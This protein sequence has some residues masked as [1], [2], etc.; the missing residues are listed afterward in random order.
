VLQRVKSASVTVDEKTVSSIG[1][2]VMALVGLHESDTT[3]DLAYC[4]KKLIA[5]RLWENENAKP[6]R[7]SV[8]Q[9]DYEVLLVSQFTL[10]GDVS[11]K[12]HT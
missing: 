9:Q 8:R 10:Y 3:R 1:R 2:G 7:K 12:K 6:W 4:A 5:C 11:N